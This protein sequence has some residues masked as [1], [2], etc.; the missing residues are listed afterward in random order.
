[1]FWGRAEINI[2]GK[3]K[4]LSIW[5]KLK[6]LAWGEGIIQRNILNNKNYERFSNLN[7]KSCENPISRFIPRIIFPLTIKIIKMNKASF[8]Y[9]CFYLSV[10]CILTKIRY[11]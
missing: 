8:S 1:M 7:T 3:P 6:L 11:L 4:M 5:K 2:H 10:V 9:C